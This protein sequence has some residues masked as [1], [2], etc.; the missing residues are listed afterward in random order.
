MQHPT[1]IAP[2]FRSPPLPPASSD[3]P[4]LLSD[5]APDRGPSAAR[6]ISSR[7]PTPP[8]PKPD[9]AYRDDNNH[10]ET[11]HLLAER[12]SEPQNFTLRG[13]LVGL[14]IGVAI[15]FSNMYF[16]LQTG[17]VSSMA[18]PSALLGFA[19]FKLVA[20]YLSIPFSPVENVLVQSV[21][22]SVGTMT[23]GCGFV[24]VIPA[25]QY[26]LKP[27]ENGPLDISLW[28]LVCW[29]VGICFFGVVFAVPLR[30]EVIIREKLKFPS[31]TA[32]AL[33]IGVIHGE[34]G[35]GAVIRQD[36][37]PTANGDP[38]ERERLLAAAPP[39]D[40]PENDV[41]LTGV[42][43]MSNWRAKVRLLIASFVVSA[44]YTVF[45][46]FVPQVRDVPIL[47][48][49]LAN[50]WL[51]TLNPSPAYIGQGIIMG[52][53]TTLH[54]LL[55]AILGWG[56]L[57]PLAKNK[58]WAPG[59]VSDW[60]TGSK[61][62]IVWLSLAIMLADSL[63]SLSWL[64]LRPLVKYARIWLPR[65]SQTHW[66]DV[67]TLR[68][69]SR[70]YEYTAL[71]GTD[72]SALKRTHSSTPEDDAPPEHL[73]SNRTT[74][75]GLFVSLLLSILA[76][77]YVFGSMVPLQLNILSLFLALLLSIMGVRALGET[78]LNP[79]SGI[80][81]LTQLLIALAIPHAASNPNAVVINLVAGAVSE[82]GAL[83]AGD[84]M[85]D[86]K[87][88]HL[89]GAAPNAQFWGQMIGSAVGAVLSAVIYKLYTNVYE[90]P[91]KLFEVPTGFV[92]IFTARLVT[93]KGLPEMVGTWAVGAGVVFALGTAARVWGQ[94]RK[95]GR[96]WT[97][98]VPGGIA[99]AVGMYNVPSFTLART[100]GGIISFV[101]RDRLGRAETP[102]IVLASGLILGEGL[103]SIVNLALAS[104]SVPHF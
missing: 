57:S 65:L 72:Q 38:D 45:S 20:R 52:P 24:G 28:K 79:V 64:V 98:F 40:H 75:I 55:G 37:A 36:A 100:I 49:T 5:M 10:N 12:A 83:Q 9:D 62:W 44:V 71:D 3:A 86:L 97:K 11:R 88:G 39:Q 43:E 92:W 1:P 102:I 50:K 35:K 6:T 29:S 7:S 84:L 47:G 90:V 59:P 61:G 76:V 78:D 41:N 99:V 16:G 26:L 32:A 21:A 19:W 87:T 30:R 22:G 103:F 74:I 56:L 73:I 94:A 17:W 42:D 77:H 66:R 27:E 48:L 93:G 81:K 4:I 31:G 18:M 33:M 51:W 46:Y 58:G 69:A 85:Q 104:L 34:D 89:L 53:E 23:L 96:G 82:S 70:D 101:W 95:E 60:E 91:G 54:M 80:S 14:G 68:I 63:V 15:C 67:A 13:I 25:L 2:R 8:T